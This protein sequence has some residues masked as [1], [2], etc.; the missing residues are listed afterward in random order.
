MLCLQPAVDAMSSVSL[1]SPKGESPFDLDHDTPFLRWSDAKLSAYPG[2]IGDLVVEVKDPHRLSPLEHEAILDRLRRAN[3]AIYAGPRSADRSIP[4][5]LGRQLGFS[6][7]DKNWLSDADGLS[8]LTVAD[9]GQRANYIPYTS[10]PIQWHTDGY[11]NAA[12]RQIHGLLLHCAQPAARGGENALL[13]HELAYLLLR[14][15][16]PNFV[17]ALMDPQALTIPPGIE[18]GGVARPERK[19]PVFSVDPVSGTLHMRFTARRRNALWKD[20]PVLDAARECL[21]GILAGDRGFVLHGLLEA[22][23]GLISN[24]VLH[25]RA[26]F[27]DGAGAKRLLYRARFY[28]RITL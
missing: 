12:D 10:R 17:R 6:Q 22:G 21:T 3:M 13:D 18:A 25:D 14:A 27:E 11:Y 5:A 24:N 26:G 20:D 9:D 19:G 28:D 8:S 15:E 23:M 4:L 16:D 1:Q 7:L 2:S